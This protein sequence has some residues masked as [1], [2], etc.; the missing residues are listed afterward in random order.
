M[1]ENLSEEFILQIM[2]YLL[3]IGIFAGSVNH[4][5]KSLE[6]KQDEH[7][8]FMKRIAKLEGDSH[9]RLYR[10]ER[11]EEAIFEIKELLKGVYDG[12]T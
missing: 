11:I 12:E 2:V 10:I 5:I 6:K 4:R 9:I 7:N 1:F 3:S 8:D